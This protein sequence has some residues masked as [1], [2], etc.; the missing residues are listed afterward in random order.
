MEKFRNLLNREHW[1]VT[2]NNASAEKGFFFWDFVGLEPS[3]VESPRRRESNAFAGYTTGPS[4]G[5]SGLED[6]PVVYLANTFDS[7]LRGDSVTL[8]S[9]PTKPQTRLFELADHNRLSLSL[10]L[11]FS[12]SSYLF[13]FS[14][15]K[16]K[17][18][19]VWPAK[20]KG[21]RQ[22]NNIHNKPCFQ[23]GRTL[24][25]KT[26][27]TLGWP[28]GV[29]DNRLGSQWA[30]SAKTLWQVWWLGQDLSPQHLQ[31]TMKKKRNHLTTEELLNCKLGTKG[32]FFPS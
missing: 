25:R 23:E 18:F 1:V 6:S 31:I 2:N 30:G 28:G 17:R 21:C 14:K 9:S 10:P 12:S 26:E 32:R 4:S 19:V 22:S 8:G 24:F 5:W 16:W 29:E 20:L 27:L 15:Q 11:S 13:S 7:R 3:G